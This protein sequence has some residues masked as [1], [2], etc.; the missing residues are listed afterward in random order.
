MQVYLNN[1]NR[2]ILQGNS[3]CTGYIKF[4]NKRNYFIDP[5]IKT[6]I[7]GQL[8]SCLLTSRLRLYSAGSIYKLLEEVMMLLK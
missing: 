8:L 4:E 2:I 5:K 7:A 3:L 6:E 1:E